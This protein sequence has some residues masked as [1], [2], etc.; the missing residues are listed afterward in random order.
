MEI[1]KDKKL[2]LASSSPR[3][4]ELMKGLDIPFETRVYEVEENYPANLSNKEI[5]EYLARLKASVFENKLEDK[6]I[7]ITSDTIVLYNDQLLVKPKD[8]KQAR[9]MLRKLSGNM[10][11]VLTSVCLT[12]RTKQVCFTEESKVYFKKLDE[13]EIDYYIDNYNPYDKAGG[14]GIQDWLGFIAIEKIEGSYY[15]I[16]GLPTHRLYEVL[17]HF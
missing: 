1:L 16:M 9:E 5:P 3:R 8:R 2:I 6:E 14:Y 13:N 17:K 10:H 11:Q 15:N 12:S 4:Q 7:V